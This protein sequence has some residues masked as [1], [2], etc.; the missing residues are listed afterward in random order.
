LNGELFGVRKRGRPGK[1]WFQNVKDDLRIMTIVN[2]KRRHR[3]EI[4]GG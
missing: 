1:K 4:Y 3:N 2:G